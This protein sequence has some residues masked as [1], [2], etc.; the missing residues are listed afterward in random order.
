MGTHPPQRSRPEAPG[1]APQ[2]PGCPALLSFGVGGRASKKGPW[3][4]GAG[5]RGRH[6]PCNL[7]QRFGMWV[8]E[9]WGSG[10]RQLAWAPRP[11]ARVSHVHPRLCHSA[12]A[13]F[14]PQR[15]L[16]LGDRRDHR[17]S[18]GNE[19]PRLLTT[20]AR[21]GTQVGWQLPAPQTGA[22]QQGPCHSP[23]GH[24]GWV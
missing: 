23:H 22:L 9:L 13:P 7:V 18:G 6:G 12:S 24:G 19:C 3:K 5:Q 16:L 21:P 14:C 11:I 15:L 17:E 2:L 8:S 1:A 4:H 20:S 10:P